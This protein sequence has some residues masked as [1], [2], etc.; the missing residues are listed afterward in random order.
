M[1]LPD[2][3]HGA[4]FEGEVRDL[5]DGFVAQ[6]ESV[7]TFDEVDNA[8]CRLLDETTGAELARYTLSG[9]G[10]HT[11]QIMAKVCR[12]GGCWQLA[13]LGEPASGA[14]FQALLPVIDRHL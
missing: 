4:P 7:A 10:S 14:A 1:G 6:F 12:T 9:G 11:A 3:S 5:H 8:Y 2:A 13:A